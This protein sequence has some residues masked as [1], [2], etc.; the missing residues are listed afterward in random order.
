MEKKLFISDEAIKKFGKEYFINDDVFDYEGKA[1]PYDYVK[2]DDGLLLARDDM[3]NLY[4]QVTEDDS[5]FTDVEELE[6]A[7]C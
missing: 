3:D 1:D 7:S 6:I 2:L 4:L 5:C